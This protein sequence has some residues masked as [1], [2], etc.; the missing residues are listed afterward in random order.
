MLVFAVSNTYLIIYV[1][2]MYRCVGSEPFVICVTCF[3]F[4]KSLSIT[5]IKQSE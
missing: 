1:C 2:I 5:S 3:F 4:Y